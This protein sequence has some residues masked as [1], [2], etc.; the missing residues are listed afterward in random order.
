MT[1][2]VK[3]KAERQAS[4]LNCRRTK[5]GSVILLLD[6]AFPDQR[7][8]PS[9]WHLNLKISAGR[10]DQSSRVLLGSCDWSGTYNCREQTLTVR[11]TL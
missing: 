6:S 11:R 2:K 4:R 7:H 8:C 9:R 3:V 1:M 10:S 5:L